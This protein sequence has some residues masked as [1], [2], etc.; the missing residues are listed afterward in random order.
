MEGDLC[1]KRDAAGFAKGL[2]YLAEMDADKREELVTDARA[3]VERAFSE[4]RL[5]KDIEG[6][7]SELM[8]GQGKY[9]WRSQ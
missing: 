1:R 4:K 6:L 7:Y 3:F 9:G 2:K 8:K 5:L